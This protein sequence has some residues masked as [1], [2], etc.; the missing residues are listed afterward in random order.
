M[1]HDVS[2]AGSGCVTRRPTLYDGQCR[3]RPPVLVDDGVWRSGWP[4]YNAAD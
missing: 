1:N 4:E 3:R 2:A